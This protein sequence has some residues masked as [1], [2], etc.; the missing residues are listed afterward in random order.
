MVQRKKKAKKKKKVIKAGPGSPPS[1]ISTLMAALPLFICFAIRDMMNNTLSILPNLAGAAIL[2]Q[3]LA[4]AFFWRRIEH[5]AL[6]GLSALYVIGLWAHVIFRGLSPYIEAPATAINL[7]AMGFSAAIGFI[8]LAIWTMKHSGPASVGSIL[9]SFGLIALTSLSLT[10]S[11]GELMA[12][13]ELSAKLAEDPNVIRADDMEEIPSNEEVIR[14][15]N[16]VSS[17]P[18]ALNDSTEKE[19]PYDMDSKPEE[20]KPE[21]IESKLPKATKTNPIKKAMKRIKKAKKKTPQW[22]Y[23]GKLGP[24]HWGKTAAYRTCSRGKEQSPVNIPEKWDIYDHLRIFNKPMDYLVKDVHKNLRVDFKYGIQTQIVNR[25]F[26]VKHIDIHSPSE[27]TYERRK[28]PMEF[29]IYHKDHRGRPAVI[30]VLGI[31]G[32]ENPEVQKIIDYLPI[33]KGRAI[34]PRGVRFNMK[35]FLPSELKSFQY[36]GSHT[37]PPCTEGVLWNV[38]NNPIELSKAQIEALKAKYDGN[39]RPVQPLHHRE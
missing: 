18:I 30:S 26:E 10:G 21:N 12:P 15:D 1:L 25:L 11:Q 33:A 7:T 28:F 16:A 3:G 38:M 23:K 36:Y 32:N 2:F 4:M 22:T 20:S 5:Q 6:H 29:Q 27:H 24:P 34:S 8:L 17:A 9:A 13:M 14:A 31:E 35:N 37:Q 39:A 19:E